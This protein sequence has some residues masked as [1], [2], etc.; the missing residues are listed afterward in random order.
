[1]IAVRVAE[2]DGPRVLGLPGDGQVVLLLLALGRKHQQSLVQGAWKLAPPECLDV[3]AAKVAGHIEVQLE[4]EDDDH[5]A[6]VESEACQQ[7]RDI[8]DGHH[9]AEVTEERGRAERE[10]VYG[11]PPDAHWRRDPEE[12]HADKGVEGDGPEGTAHGAPHA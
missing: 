11:A 4:Y 6:G 12:Q 8:N 10:V 1:M 7:P 5:L 2:A 9:Y 3:E